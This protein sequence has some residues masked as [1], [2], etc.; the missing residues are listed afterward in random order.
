MEEAQAVLV[1]NRAESSD[2]DLA[3]GEEEGSIQSDLDLRTQSYNA[4][5]ESSKS[6]RAEAAASTKTAVPAA[7]LVGDNAAADNDVKPW[8]TWKGRLARLVIGCFTGFASALTG[9]S[10]PVVLLPILFI[11]GWQ[12][13]DA[14]GSAQMIQ[15]PIAVA[16]TIATQVLSSETPPVDYALGGCIAAGIVPGAFAGAA[17]AFSL[18]VRYD[19]P[20]FCFESLKIY[21]SPTLVWGGEG[22]YISRYILWRLLPAIQSVLTCLVSLTSS[23]LQMTSSPHQIKGTDSETCDFSRARFCSMLFDWQTNLPD[24]QRWRRNEPHQPHSAQH[25]GCV[26]AAP[27]LIHALCRGGGR[28]GSI[29]NN[30]MLAVGMEYRYN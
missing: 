27:V 18:P 20:D 19:R 3:T 30:G 22:R 23:P 5:M 2:S 1:I 6:K 12:V 17:V 4:A 11:F 26:N 25:D 7:A 10:G 15:F 28:R 8:E 9:T 24:T 16:A 13:H 29:Y 21:T 14:A